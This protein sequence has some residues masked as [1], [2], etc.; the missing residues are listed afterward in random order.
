MGDPDPSYDITT[1]W[2]CSLSLSLSLCN[3]GLY[4]SMGDS[5][6]SYDITTSW[7]CSLSLSL[8]NPGLYNSLDSFRKLLILRCFRPDK[9]LPAIQDFVQANLGKKYVGCDLCVCARVIC[10]NE[11][12]RM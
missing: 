12:F 5:D 11:C 4:N 1:S 8:C 2:H 3:P 10:S 6:S 9:V 7:H